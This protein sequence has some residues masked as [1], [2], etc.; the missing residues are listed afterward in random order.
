MLLRTPYFS[1]S[2]VFENPTFFSQKI[3]I[4]ERV[5]IQIGRRLLNLLLARA[6]A[7]A[8]RTRGPRAGTVPRDVDIDTAEK[9]KISRK[10]QIR[11]GEQ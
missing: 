2:V 6:W 4:F 9:A 8:R 3:Q 5:K 7:H 1:K 11:G 10:F